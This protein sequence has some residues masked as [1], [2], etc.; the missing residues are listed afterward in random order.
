M[1]MKGK[2]VFFMVVALTITCIS[3]SVFAQDGQG[4]KEMA[5]FEGREV[6]VDT[7]S[8]ERDGTEVVVWVK[9]NYSKEAQR[10]EYVSKIEKAMSSTPSGKKSWDKKWS[11]KYANLGYTLSKRIYNCVDSKY[12]VLEIG[13]YTKGGKKILQNKV[14]RKNTS[15]KSVD[16]DTIGDILMFEVC[17]NY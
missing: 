11:K 7:V 4:W 12:M 1:I 8:I 13:E 17:D 5:V 15:W 3:S 10:D 2:N 14:K 9:E 16:F 6:Y